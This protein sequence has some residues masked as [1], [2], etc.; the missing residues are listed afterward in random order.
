[1]IKKTFFMAKTFRAHSTNSLRYEKSLR[2]HALE[3]AAT[4][5]RVMAEVSGV[6]GGVLVSG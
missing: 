3:S 4:P 2:D 1:M 6:P 5:W